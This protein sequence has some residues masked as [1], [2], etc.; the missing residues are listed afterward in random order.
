[1]GGERS[2]AIV[3][4]LRKPLSENLKFQIRRFIAEKFDGLHARNNSNGVS[5]E[6]TRLIDELGGAICSMI[7]RPPSAPIGRY[8]SMIL[9]SVVIWQSPH[10]PNGSWA[11]LNP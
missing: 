1:M 2:A 6:C 8:S 10:M 4:T 5:T 7:L 9:P 11:N 3:N